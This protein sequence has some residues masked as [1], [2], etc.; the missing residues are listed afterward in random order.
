MRLALQPEN[1]LEFFLLKMGKISPFPL[2]PMLGLGMGQ[3]LITATRLGLFD[4]L[5]DRPKTAAMLAEEL[6]CDLHGLEILLE[7]LDGFGFLSYRQGYYQLTAESAQ[8]LTN[9]SSSIQDSL[10]LGGEIARQMVLLEEDIR[11]GEVPNFHFNPP[12]P[13]CYSHYITSLGESGRRK[14]PKIIEWAN[15][16]P[17]PKK[18]LDVAGGS[19]EYSIAFCQYFPDLKAD[20]LDL[21]YASEVGIQTIEK[22]G[23]GDRICYQEGDLFQLEWQQGYDLV[24]LSNILH[25]FVA[26]QCQIILRKAF[27]SL[28]PGGKVL[29]HEVFH[30]GRTGKITAPM[31]LFS[32]M[33][34]V[35]CGGRAWSESSYLE[36]LEEA[37]FQNLRSFQQNLNLLLLSGEKR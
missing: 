33:F 21:P 5:N 16:K 6:A 2:L 26:D 19:G 36:W 37:G 10:K 30:S 22:A 29:I 28:N 13:T 15:L 7:S 14:A 3:A 12:S 11:T 35:T 31:G 25:V 8:W 4:R 17:P 23:L 9:S 27:A 1:L 20:I 34:Y 24:F 18:L 32:L